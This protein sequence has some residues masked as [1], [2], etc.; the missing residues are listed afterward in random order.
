MVRLLYSG[1]MAG[2]GEKEKQEAISA[3]AKLGIRGLVEVTKRDCKGRN[4][5]GEG[6]HTE[7]GVQTEPL[8][9]EENEGTRG[10]WRREVR[11][12]R[13]F[14]W[15]D[16]LS[17]GVKNT[18][19]QTEELQV[20]TAPPSHAAASFETID[21]AALQTLGQTD[22]HL[23]P[24]QLPYIPI[25]VVYPLDERQTHQPSPT[26]MDCTAAGH[27]SVAVL[28][29]PYT[30]V[31]PSHLPFSSQATPWAAYPQSWWSGPQGAARD[32]AEAQEW[33]NERFEQFQGNIPGYISYFLNPHKEE[34]SCRGR[35]RRRRGAGVG[36]A[37]RAGT[38]ERRARR[39]RATTAGRGRGG[40]T[41][42]VD[43]QEVGVSKLQKMF[44]QRRGTR[45]SRPGQ[46]GGAVGRKLYL[47][48][49]E[50]LKTAKSCQR[51]RGR[52]KVWEFNQSGD[53]IEGGE[54]YTQRGRRS[55]PQQFNQVRAL[56]Y[57]R[58]ICDI[59]LNMSPTQYN[60]M[61]G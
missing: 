5:E 29:P 10:R 42:T 50:L 60:L 3:A 37:R 35:A 46:G 23:L 27:T 40:L 57:L 39:P 18:W 48:T 59:I 22:S 28:A 33:E 17:D 55:T 26:P 43:V 49:R 31:P 51:R 56:T 47:K 19:T 54:S 61:V 45:A 11:D 34:G 8:M 14:L 52:G 15:K 4:E 21:I 36:G 44:L 41:Q 32:V 58:P 13:T 25:S 7:V 12:G 30:S 9:P 2:E 38:G 24:P 16:T 20:N 6:R 1:E 53:V